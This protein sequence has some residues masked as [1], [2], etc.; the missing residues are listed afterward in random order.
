MKNEIQIEEEFL[1]KI[2]FEYYLEGLNFRSFVEHDSS[3]NLK[4]S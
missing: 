2:Q 4:K 1:V 3:I